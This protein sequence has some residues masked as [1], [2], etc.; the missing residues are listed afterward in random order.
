MKKWKKNH[1]S[2]NYKKK[3]KKCLQMILVVRFCSNAEILLT[4]NKNMVHSF[5]NVAETATI[6][7]SGV[8]KVSKCCRYGNIYGPGNHRVKWF[9]FHFFNEIFIYIIHMNKN[10]VTTTE[11]MLRILKFMTATFTDFQKSWKTNCC[12]FGNIF[13]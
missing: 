5:K 7:F 10:Y 13:E 8:L 11:T 1:L 9:F 12:R 6:G 4:I 2:K 3:W